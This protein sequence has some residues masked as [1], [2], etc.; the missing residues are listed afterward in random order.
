M[1]D[2]LIIKKGDWWY[3][4][5]TYKGVR[6]RDSLKTKDRQTAIEHLF[7]LQLLV[8]EGRYQFH[9]VKFEALAKD[10]SPQVDRE[11]KLR[12]LRVHLEPVF[13]GKRLSEVD[14]QSWA[15][16]VARDN[17]EST[18]LSIMRVAR[19]L[20]FQV[21]HKSIKFQPGKKFDGTQI[22]SEEMALD[23]VRILAESPRGKKYASI[24]RV[25]MYSTMPLSDLIH[26]RK[27]DVVFSGKDAGITYARRK[28][29]YKGKSALFVPMTNKLR[30]AFA[31][32]PTPLADEGRWFPPFTAF[33]VSKTVSRAF[34]Q[35]GWHHGRAMH[36]FRHFGACYLVRCGVPLTTIQELMGHS[37]FNTT[38]I[39]A[40]TDRETLIEGMKKFDAI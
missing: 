23:I 2:D 13:K 35:A 34:I 5:C 33:A 14:V 28:T 36:N 31:G 18:A 11:N 21:S 1:G 17:P 7:E 15:E 3:A 24:C 40:R 29:R 30:E 20:G 10:Y 4:D 12:I 19:E 38:L 8:R 26:L 27:Q 32:V 6:I 22:L 16:S 37:D 39:Y 25:A 9:K